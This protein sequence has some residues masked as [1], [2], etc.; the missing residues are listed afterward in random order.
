MRRNPAFTIIELIVVLLVLA[1][2]LLAVSNFELFSRFQINDLDRNIKLQNDVYYV[3]S[4]ISKD[5]NNAIGAVNDWPVSITSSG[6]NTSLITIYLDYNKNGVKDATP[7]DRVVAYE[8][9]AASY[10]LRQ[11]A[12]YSGSP[13]VYSVLSNKITG[14]QC[15]TP[16]VN[17]YVYFSIQARSTPSAAVSASNPEIQLRSAGEMPSLSVN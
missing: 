16:G 12:D 11:Y 1:L 4:L 15:I 2:I 6:G 10:S 13:A 9:D 17:S 14:F 5:L 3:S 7:T 8:Y